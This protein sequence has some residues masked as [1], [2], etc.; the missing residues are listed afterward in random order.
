MTQ[1]SYTLAFERNDGSYRFDDPAVSILMTIG[2]L[3]ERVAE[4]LRF[5]RRDVDGNPLTY[6]M[7]R[8]DD[9]EIPKAKTVGDA[10]TDQETLT[11]CREYRN[12]SR[13]A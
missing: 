3:T 9:T 13:P 4:R 11:V 12:A 7:L 6:S 8:G 1:S 10:V 5:P 2:D